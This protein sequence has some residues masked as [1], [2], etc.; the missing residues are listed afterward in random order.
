MNNQEIFNDAAKAY[1]EFPLLDAKFIDE[2]TRVDCKRIF[3]LLLSQEQL[4]ESIKDHTDQSVEEPYSASS[5]FLATLNT[6]LKD[7]ESQLIQYEG[8]YGKL[9]NIPYTN[10]A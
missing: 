9:S 10:Q 1:R 5:P 6:R 3:G 4:L 2:A 8:K 7:V